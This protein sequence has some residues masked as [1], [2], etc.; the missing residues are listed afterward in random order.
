[1]RLTTRFIGKDAFADCLKLTEVHIPDLVLWCKMQLE[2]FTANPLYM[3]KNLYV[4]G[5]LVTHLEIPSTV[6]RIADGAFAG[7]TS[8]VS[9]SIPMGVTE[10]GTAAF[11]GCT[12]LQS[13]LIQESVLDIGDF[14]FKGCT[15][16]TS[17]VIPKS[18]VSIG[19]GAF[20]GCSLLTAVTFANASG[21]RIGEGM[22]MP[23]A[24]FTDPAKAA[25]Y[26]TS[27]YYDSQWKRT[28]E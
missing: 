20:R 9:V 15:S 12:A 19:S 21:W 14:V 27:I 5:E 16:M 11:S 23:P 24:D 6:T 18:V 25:E 13:V 8:I 17:V 28:E 4:D 7:C 2:G 26:L 3:A 22:H 10:I 1:M